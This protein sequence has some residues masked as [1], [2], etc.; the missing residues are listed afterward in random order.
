MITLVSSQKSL[1]PNISAGS[2]ICDGV[3][4]QYNKQNN[5]L[6]ILPLFQSKIIN[7]WLSFVDTRIKIEKSTS[8]LT[9][10]QY[11]PRKIRLCMYVVAKDDEIWSVESSLK[12]QG[13]KLIAGKTQSSVIIK[14]EW[15]S[16]H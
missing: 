1:P 10:K 9:S 8:K 7:R 5:I 12:N 6:S 14:D 16:N 2:V 3:T 15:M 4:I 13:H 11:F